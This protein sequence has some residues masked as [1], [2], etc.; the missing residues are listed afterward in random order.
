MTDK[1]EAKEKVLFSKSYPLCKGDTLR[2]FNNG[3]LQFE[4]THE[5][6]D[7]KVTVKIEM[8]NNA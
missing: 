2:L 8:E 3:F 7:K 5:G 6:P 1:P 4:Y